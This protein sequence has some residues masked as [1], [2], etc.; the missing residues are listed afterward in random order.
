[1]KG[2]LDP[3]FVND[4]DGGGNYIKYFYYE[5]YVKLSARLL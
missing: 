4:D 3:S 1:M 2:P 5:L